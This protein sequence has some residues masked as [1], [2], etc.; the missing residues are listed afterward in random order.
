[1]VMLSEFWVALLEHWLSERTCLS[2]QKL[3]SLLEMVF[4]KSVTQEMI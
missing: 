2:Q 1:M 3:V 4:G